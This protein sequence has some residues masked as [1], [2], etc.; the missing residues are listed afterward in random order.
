MNQGCGG[1]IVGDKYIVTAAHCTYVCKSEK[2]VVE[3]CCCDNVGEISCSE[4]FTKCGNNP[5]VY[6]MGGEDVVVLCGEWEIGNFS[7]DESG[8]DF[9][10]E[11]SVLEIRRHPNFKIIRGKI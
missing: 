5:K 1:T 6:E 7:A 8:E 4:D 9:N 11:L 3:N 10:I 2:G